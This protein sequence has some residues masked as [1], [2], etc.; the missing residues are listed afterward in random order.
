MGNMY[1]DEK[2]DTARERPSNLE[3]MQSA[4]KEQFYEQ[5][6]DPNQDF[7]IFTIGNQKLGGV[8]SLQEKMNMADQNSS[9]SSEEEDLPEMSDQ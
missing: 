9:S 1:G 4:K 3:L 8:Q 2:Q 7:Q 6:Y 5:Q